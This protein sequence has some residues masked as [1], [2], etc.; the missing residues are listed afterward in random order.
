MQ[1]HSHQ[2]TYA[3]MDRLAV[4]LFP[5]LA[6]HDIMTASRHGFTYQVLLDLDVG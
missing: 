4:L 5:E 3:V 6:R 2:S 1:P